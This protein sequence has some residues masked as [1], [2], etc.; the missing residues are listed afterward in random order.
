V[1]KLAL[2][3]LLNPSPDIT[4]RLATT[5]QLLVRS[6]IEIGRLLGSMREDGDAV[7]GNL[8]S[9]MLFLSKLVHVEPA[10]GYMLLCYSDHK[11]ANT[12]A[13]AARSLT[14]R[15]NHRGAQFAFTGDKPRQTAYG[16][17][18]C[19]QFGLPTA[20]LG[21]QRRRGLARVQV[22]AQAPVRCDL[23][24][25]LQAFASRVVDVSLDGI[26]ALISDPTIPLCA[27]TRLEHARIW[28][29]QVEPF[30]VDLEV[31]HVTRATL[32]NGQRVSRIGCKVLGQREVLEE[33]I[34]LFII[35]LA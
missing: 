35:D 21:M 23:R 15:C 12:E 27:G 10:S 5:G 19:I 22:P 20:I 8:P 11:A 1:Y 33:L 24:M 3:W 29:P 14:L 31:R 32:A 17:Q 2:W 7:T 6:G 30:H 4:S 34:R 9:Q 26:G 28:H 25:G 18:P 16:S 13:L